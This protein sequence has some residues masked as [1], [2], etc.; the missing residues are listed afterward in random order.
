MQYEP[1][2]VQFS[3][4]SNEQAQSICESLLAQKLIA[5]A[6]L[7]APV[8]SMY[9]WEG[10]LEH[11]EEIVVQVKTFSIF[12]KAIEKQILEMHT[13]SVPEILALPIREISHYYYVWMIQELIEK[14][15][16]IKV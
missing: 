1:I 2:L 4:P 14:K 8:K 7:S 3:V 16:A 13:Y 10:A 6:H 5:C 12:W 11:A 9:Y 15:N